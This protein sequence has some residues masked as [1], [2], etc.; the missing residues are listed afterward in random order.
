MKDYAEVLESYMIAEE[1]IFSGIKNKFKKK[2]PEKQVVKRSSKIAYAEYES[3]Y[4]P[5]IKKMLALCKSELPKL[6]KDPAYKQYSES[7]IM[8]ADTRYGDIPIEKQFPDI[9]VVSYNLDT[10]AKTSFAN[11]P[12]KDRKPYEN[13]V[14]MVLNM[15]NTCATKAGLEGKAVDKPELY[16]GRAGKLEFVIDCDYNGVK[17]DVPND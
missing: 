7:Y 11:V 2:Q 13:S 17:L 10:A 15:I 6:F 14:Q 9:L 12:P 1:G 4:E 5:K 3:Q 16:T 8:Y